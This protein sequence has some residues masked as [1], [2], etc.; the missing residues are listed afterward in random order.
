MTADLK[1]IVIGTSH[2]IQCGNA[3]DADIARLDQALVEALKEYGC[4]CIAEEMSEEAIPMW[5]GKST[6]GR[7]KAQAE[8]LPHLFCDPDTSERRD[9]GIRA[10]YE[11][12]GDASIS[13]AP[14]D[15]PS[16]V[17]RNYEKRERIW[18]D[19][20][21]KAGERSVLFICGDDHVDSFAKRAR[22]LG[23]EVIVLNRVRVEDELDFDSGGRKS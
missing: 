18:I 5:G 13:T 10:G 17:K 2:Y 16:E 19:R 11:I 22:E 20:L 21:S 15:V 1:L 12:E 3:K 8:G 9:L 6:V 4:R 14:V 7:L 23:I